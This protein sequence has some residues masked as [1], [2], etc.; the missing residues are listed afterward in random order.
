MRERGVSRLS[1]EIFLSHS[2]EKY[3]RG[4]FY[5]FSDFGY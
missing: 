4:I 1:V 2:A 3:R 5:C